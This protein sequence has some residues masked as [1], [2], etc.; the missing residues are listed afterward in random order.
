MQDKIKIIDIG[1]EDI[2][3]CAAN[4]TIES[5]ILILGTNKFRRLPITKLGKIEGILTIT[6]ILRIIS[7]VGIQNSFKEKVEDW[8]T[9][10]PKKIN[11]NVDVD[12]AIKEMNRYN[13]GSLLLIDDHNP[14]MCKGIV[15]ERDILNHYECEK[16]NDILLKSIDGKYMQLG[17]HIID[18]DTLLLDAIK[19][20]ADNNTHRVV[21]RSKEGTGLYGLLSA[22][23]ITRLIKDQR[24]EIA[25]NSN[26]LD[27]VNAG[28]VS[29]GKITSVNE[30]VTLKTAI[31]IMRKEKFG[32]LPVLG[33]NGKIIGIF[34]ERSLLH[35]ID[36]NKC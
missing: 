6:D 32:A 29:S 9:K 12:S 26:F 19:I 35:Y 1:E 22:N 33:D 7:K 4:R 21:V 20:M 31:D 14:D 17:Y 16:W 5:A 30:D 8:M 11:L 25:N 28:Y 10:T 36:E 3:G 24:E 27:S 2:I 34:S 13:I 23:D 15:T 18:Y